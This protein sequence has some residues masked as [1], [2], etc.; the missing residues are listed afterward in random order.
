MVEKFLEQLLRRI[1][2]EQEAVMRPLV[3]NSI[4]NM[5]DYR[6]TN[7]ILKGLNSS[8]EIIK[9]LYKDI[10]EDQFIVERERS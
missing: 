4:Q 5:E 9:K 3:N 10:F 1:R 6:Y 8:E 2:L 7:G